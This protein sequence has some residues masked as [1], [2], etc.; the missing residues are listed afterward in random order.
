MSLE[1]TF[2]GQR[3]DE[4]VEEVVKNHPFVLFWPGIK[5][6]ILLAIPVGVF[7]FTGASTYFTLAT[8]I[9][10]LSAFA[11]FARPY[12]EYAASVLI[13]T[14]QRVMYLAQRG[15]FGRK[16]IETELRNI[17]D[18]SS[19]TS[20]AIRMSLGFGD[21]IIRTAG[22]GIGTEIIVKNI[23]DPFEIQQEVTKRIE[24]QLIR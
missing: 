14:N 19:D 17:V 7:F 3:A 21:L 1:F 16:I 2:K 20:G 15:F 9:F 12:Y 4:T 5:A 10:V 23:S 24:K 8:L 18:I 22:A 6:V 11:V 13:L